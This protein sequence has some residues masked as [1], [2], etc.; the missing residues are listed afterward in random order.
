MEIQ[1]KVRT[2]AIGPNNDLHS[3]E[4]TKNV[5]FI[6]LFLFVFP[7]F[8]FC[9]EIHTGVLCEFL[10]PSLHRREMSF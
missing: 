8:S 2:A 9:M 10:G 1:E 6:F 5:F 3:R 4:N 7:F